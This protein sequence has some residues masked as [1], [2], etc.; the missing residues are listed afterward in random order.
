MTKKVLLLSVC[1][2]F[3]FSLFSFG[4]DAEI[5]RLQMEIQKNGYRFTVG[6]TSV[7]HIPLKDLCGLKEPANWRETGKFADD[8]LGRTTRATPPSSFD[9]RSYGNVTSVKNQGSC[10]SCWAFATIGCYEAAILVDGGSSENLSEEFLLDCNTSGYSCSGGWWAFNDLDDGVP[11]ESCYPYVGSKGTCNTSCTKYYPI[12]NWYY[13]GSSSG[14]P[15]T[16]SIKQAI[17]DYGPVAAAVYATSAF[18]SYNSGIFDYCQSGSVNH[19]I[20]LVGWSD[21]GGYWILKNSWGTGWGESGYMRISYGC[22][23]VGY[24]AA[25]SIPEDEGGGG[26]TY[27]RLMNRYS[28]Y[29]LDINSGSSYVYHYSYNGNYDKHWEFVD[30]GSGWYALINRYNGNALDVS[31]SGNYCYNYVYNGNTDK[32]WSVNDLGNGYYRLD[33]R[34]RGTSLDVGSG[35]YV[36]H[37][38]WNGNTDKQWQIIEVQ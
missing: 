17:Y 20:V 34:Y 4:N 24:A 16:S 22:N 28:G 11:R 6:K 36:Y 32:H 7:S 18:Q 27:Y 19:G 1:L 35:S 31:G 21:S 29:A 9:W 26:G 10:G 15:S 38:T 30:V 14:V 3:V 33:N 25:F 8:Y 13:V 23:Q 5:K 12:E 2:A 37:Y